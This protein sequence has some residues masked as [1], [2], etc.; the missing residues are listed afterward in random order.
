MPRISANGIELEYES[1][2]DGH[3]LILVQ[4]IGMQLVF[5]PDA[6][7]QQLAGRGFQVV[8]F[9]H[10]DIGRSTWL[11][12]LG[13]PPW[14]KTLVRA[15]LGLSVDA[16]YT[17]E[18]M[19]DDIVGLLDGLGLE[20]AHLVGVSMG[21][22]IG[23]TLA[24]RHPRRLRTL[25]SVMSHPGA[26][27]YA[28]GHPH[29]IRKMLQPLPRRREAAIEHIVELFHVLN[30]PRS[31][32]DDEQIR[33]M[34]GRSWDRG[35]HPKGFVRQLAAILAS[36]DRSRALAGVRVPTLVIHGTADPLVRPAGGLAT[37]RAIPGARVHLVEGMGHALPNWVWPEILD[38]IETHCK[39]WEA[40]AA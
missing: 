25:T 34:A 21:G 13:L 32:F 14:R 8:R 6:F 4:G 30:G 17:L 28:I 2:G 24:I 40:L 1:I 23:Q 31:S 9:D 7:Y 35:T 10:R 29:A 33:E 22:M 39:A 3:P 18:D 15:M 19:S 11:D 20:T 26:R 37:A 5:W 27:R 16:P 12:H 38:A 36:G